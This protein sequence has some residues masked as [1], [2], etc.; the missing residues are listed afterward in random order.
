VYNRAVSAAEIQAIYNAGNAGKCT[1]AT[2]PF[3]FAQPTDQIVALG[4][5]AIFSVV[6]GSL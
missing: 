4:S 2:P 3:I 1:D 5:N 6:A